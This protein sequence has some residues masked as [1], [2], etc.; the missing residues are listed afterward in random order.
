MGFVCSDKHYNSRWRQLVF[1]K[2]IIITT[3]SSVSFLKEEIISLG[4]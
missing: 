3:S 2:D 4:A 1:I